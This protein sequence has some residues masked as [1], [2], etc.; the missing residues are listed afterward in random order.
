MAFYIY[1]ITLLIDVILFEAA[2]DV[3]VLV[4]ELVDL[5]VAAH[6]YVVEVLQVAQLR[7]TNNLNL[8]DY[9]IF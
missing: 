2:L 6:G 4:E 5:A 8:L 1:D 3:V 9:Q 7:A